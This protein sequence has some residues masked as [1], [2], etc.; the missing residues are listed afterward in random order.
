MYKIYRQTLL[1]KFV[2]MLMSF[3]V[4]VSSISSFS[5]SYVISF[6]YLFLFINSGFCG[7]PIKSGNGRTWWGPVNTRDVL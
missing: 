4:S 3:V 5:I 1:C 2:Y 6:E 7:F